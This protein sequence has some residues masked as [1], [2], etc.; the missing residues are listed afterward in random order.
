MGP[1]LCP[2]TLLVKLLAER[3]LK[4][5]VMWG[6]HTSP[7]S[8]K[9]AYICLL[10]CHRENDSLESHMRTQENSG[11]HFYLGHFQVGSYRY[12]SLI[13]GLYTL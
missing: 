2:V 7:T 1:L 3:K 9:V 13:E 4:H 5:R 8:T 11:I 10:N 12:R 6:A